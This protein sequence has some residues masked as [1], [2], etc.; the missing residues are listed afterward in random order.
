MQQEK[1][2]ETSSKHLPSRERMAILQKSDR[3]WQ[4]DAI[5]QNVAEE[6]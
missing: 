2:Y 4:I 1:L 6:I 3:F 5:L